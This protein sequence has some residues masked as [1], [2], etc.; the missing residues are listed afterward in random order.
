[1]P[2]FLHYYPG[3][4][5]ETYTQLDVYHWEAMKHFIQPMLENSQQARR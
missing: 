3:L 2:A 1:M 4:T 5:P